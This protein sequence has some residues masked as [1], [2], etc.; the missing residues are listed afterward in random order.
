MSE[1][2]RVLVVDDDD[3]MRNGL[4]LTISR[5]GIDVDVAIDANDGFEKAMKTNYDL[6]ISDI[7]MPKI[8]G[9]TF[10]KMLKNAGVKTPLCFITAYATVETAVEALKLGAF[11]YIIKPFPPEVIEE[12]IERVFSIN[13]LKQ[14]DH[15]EDRK[16]VY[17]SRYMAEIFNLAL[18]VASSDATVLITGESGTGKEVLAKFIHENSRRKAKPFVA[19][20]CAAIPENLVESEFFGYE[21]G[22]FTGAEKR[23]PG[24]FEI[25][26][27]GTILLDEIGE[28]PINLQAKLLRVLQEKEIERLGGLKPIPVD[29]RIIATT[30]R[31]L[32]EEVK[33]GN[34]REDL[35]YRLNVINLHIPPLRRR[36]DDI[37]HL[38]EFFVEKYSKLN[39]KKAKNLSEDAKSTLVNYDWPGNVREL[40]HTIE[41]AVIL[42]KGDKITSKDLFL[43]GLV[44]HEE[45]LV[46]EVKTVDSDISNDED[47]KEPEK[48]SFTNTLKNRSIADVEKELIL[49]TLKDVG[50]NRTK[51]AEIL[52]ITVRTL[53]NKLKEYRE[54]GI[55]IDKYLND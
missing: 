21:K 10:F 44:F 17:K 34:F 35:Y 28:I 50:G 36:K 45:S 38:A 31:D 30:N 25:A 42:S 29:V 9:I 51:A 2:K 6:I 32:L 46:E 1:I 55:D 11:D 18:D 14:E 8:D 15:N 53:R 20:N 24:K 3:N 5:M 39:R 16:Y 54:Q 40:E 23:K 49:N 7:K 12:L 4:K 37:L 33:K 52:G 22:A 13:N 41:R 26:D 27:G 43:H 19:V 47:S 48:I